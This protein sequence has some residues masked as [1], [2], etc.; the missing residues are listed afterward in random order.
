M[1]WKNYENDIKNSSF[2]FTDNQLMRMKESITELYSIFKFVFDSPRKLKRPY[3]S[4][5]NYKFR[6]ERMFQ[7]PDEFFKFQ[8]DNVMSFFYTK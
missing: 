8:H 1:S 4:L 2:V 7:S 5:N 3:S 6:R